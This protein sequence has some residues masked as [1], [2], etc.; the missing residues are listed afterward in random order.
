VMS[1]SVARIIY[2]HIDVDGVKVFYRESVPDPPDAPALLLLH[3]FP[4]GSHQFRRLIDVLGARTTGR[5]PR[6]TPDSGT[7]RYLTA[8]PTAST[9][10]PTPP[11]ASCS[12]LT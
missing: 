3:G 11:R 7:P 12:G 2:R 5:S 10:S 9:G 8:S 4:S 6:T 1:A